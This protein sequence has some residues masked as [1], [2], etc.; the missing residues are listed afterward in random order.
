MRMIFNHED[1]QLVTQRGIIAA[2]ANRLKVEEKL[3]EMEQRAED[4]EDEE[5]DDEEDDVGPVKRSAPHGDRA[6]AALQP[7][8]KRQR[9]AKEDVEDSEQDEE[10]QIE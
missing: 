9:V 8:T 7:A 5:D 4:L 1:G 3:K 2:H 10:M 6:G